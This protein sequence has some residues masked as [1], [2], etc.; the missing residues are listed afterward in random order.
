MFW[1]TV[2]LWYKSLVVEYYKHY[3]AL[4]SCYFLVMIWERINEF[5]A[6]YCHN[7]TL[8][9]H[10]KLPFW[11]RENARPT[12]RVGRDLEL[13]VYLVCLSS[14]QQSKKIR[15]LALCL[16]FTMDL[17]IHNLF[18]NWSFENGQAAVRLTSQGGT[19]D[20]Y[21]TVLLSPGLVKT[22][23]HALKEPGNLYIAV[24]SDKGFYWTTV[25]WVLD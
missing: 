2:I 10:V 7:C 18:I 15:P 14:I 25:L 21:C 20:R 16:I 23:R 19:W 17:E 13:S 12:V 5:H 9:I 22:L 3:V 6:S 4:S 1:Y 11:E 24:F 8:Y